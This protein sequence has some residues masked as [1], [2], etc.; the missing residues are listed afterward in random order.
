MLT[1][2]IDVRLNVP[3][4]VGITGLILLSAGHLDLL[5]TPLGKVDI[6]GTEVASEDLVLQAESR[7]KGPNLAAIPGGSVADNLNLPVVLGIA[8]SEVSVGGD[9]LV[10]LGDGG[11][12]L[13]R[14]QVAAGL[15]V[16]EADGLLVRDETRFGLSIIVGVATVGVEEPV[17]VGIFVV[18]AGHLLLVGTLRIAIPCLLV[19]ALHELPGSVDLR[20]DVTVEQATSVTHI[21]NG[22]P[23]SKG[24]LK[25]AVSADLSAPQVGLEERGHLGIARAGVGENGEVDGKAEKV[26]QKGQNDET[27]NASSNMGSQDSNRHLGVAKLPPEIFDGVKADKSSNEQ[28]DQLNT[29]DEA[30][31]ES[32]HEEPEEPLGLEA[33]V[34]LVVE[35]GPAQSGG[36]G[37]EQKH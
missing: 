10:G 18:I 36:H 3:V 25:R 37:T 24:N 35:L 5:E 29:S 17:V 26:D 6:A 30:D 7:G 8:N 16:N 14:V 22:N 4:G 32:S 28:T 21:L 12:D 27:D 20:L 11:S 15:G 33:V 2:L 34:A 31:A 13:V 1:L 9:F 19:L 23:R